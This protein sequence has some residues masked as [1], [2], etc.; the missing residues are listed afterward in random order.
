MAQNV[1]ISSPVSMKS[2]N[3][4]LK[5]NPEEKFLRNSHWNITFLYNVSSLQ[6]ANFHLYNLQHLSA[7]IISKCSSNHVEICHVKRK[8]QKEPTIHL[9]VLQLATNLLPSRKCS[10]RIILQLESIF[11]EKVAIESLYSWLLKCG[12][13]PKTFNNSSLKTNYV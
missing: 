5:K 1:N 13:R 9:P 7:K 4:W 2:L 8:P 12:T 6:S 11:L 10:T 3:I